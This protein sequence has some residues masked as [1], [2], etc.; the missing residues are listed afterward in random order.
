MMTLEERKRLMI[1]LLGHARNPLVRGTDL[2]RDI[3]LA[4]DQLNQSVPKL[5]YL[6][7]KRAVNEFLGTL[8]ETEAG[9][10]EWPEYAELLDAL[11]TP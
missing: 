3:I 11:E 9:T 10:D 6:V 8:T 1:D 5:Q 7:L 4:V 2:G